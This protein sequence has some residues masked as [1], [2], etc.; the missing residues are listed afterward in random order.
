MSSEYE[1]K[2]KKIRISEG[3]TQVAFSHFTGVNIGS[4][5]NYENGKRGVGL[6][7]IEQVLGAKDFKKYALW[8]MT[9]ETAP[10]IGQIS[11][12]EN[13]LYKM[14][15]PNVGELKYTPQELDE[16]IKDMENSDNFIDMPDYELKKNTQL[17]IV[18]ALKDLKLDEELKNLKKNK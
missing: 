17:P 14:L 3:L 1:K 18:E 2:L 10:E 4:I 6:G 7:I 15:K 13:G 8:L 11:P 16:I 9:G 12:D 5:R